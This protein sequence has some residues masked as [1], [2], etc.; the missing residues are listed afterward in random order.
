MGSASHINIA[1][2]QLKGMSPIMRDDM[3]RLLSGQSSK[4]LRLTIVR[5]ASSGVTLHEHVYWEVMIIG[6]K[7]CFTMSEIQI[8][9][10]GVRHATWQVSNL[11]NAFSFNL[12]LENV[13]VSPIPFQLKSRSLL[14]LT[15]AILQHLAVLLKLSDA[16]G[17]AAT[18]VLDAHAPALAGELAALYV[19]CFHASQKLTVQKGK[20]TPPLPFILTEHHLA[21]QLYSISD[22]AASL[23][24]STSYVS[25]VFQ[26]ECGMSA[27]RYIIVRRLRRACDLLVENKLAINEVAHLTGWINAHYFATAFKKFTGMTPREYS[28]KLHG[29][30]VDYPPGLQLHFRHNV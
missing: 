2:S 17:D 29:Q 10:P 25:N 26:R 9:P 28:R 16:M 14:P 23:G 1:P 12:S 30:F 20:S 3:A 22:M 24:V 13:C 8:I 4:D 15:C 6:P 7:N 19:A 21:E 18:Q 5:P 27:K 11:Q